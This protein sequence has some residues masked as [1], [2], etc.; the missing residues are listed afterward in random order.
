[1]TAVAGEDGESTLVM[2]TQ[3]GRPAGTLV[4]FG[5]DPDGIITATFSNS[6]TQVLGQVALATFTN[7][8]GLIGLTDN[9]FT[10]GPNSG[11]AVVAPPRTV[12]GGR[13]AAGALEGS[14]VDLSREFIGL[15]N[16]STGF[17]ANSR[18]ITTADELLQELLL[19]AR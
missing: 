8:E 3:D 9:T 12:G 11:D 15:I 1:M 16:A 5:I 18:V 19:I 17:S 10:V 6:A 2:T 4:D 13:I 7:P 14:N